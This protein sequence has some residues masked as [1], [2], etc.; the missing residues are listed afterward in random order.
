MQP[1]TPELL[2]VVR[3]LFIAVFNATVT[4]PHHVRPLAV[5]AWQLLRSFLGQSHSM[6]KTPAVRFCTSHSRKGLQSCCNFSTC[7]IGHILKGVA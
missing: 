3:K 5:A 7:L 1:E 4:T 2:T 6:A